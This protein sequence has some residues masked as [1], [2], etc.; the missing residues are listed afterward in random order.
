[1]KEALDVRR[2]VT[3]AG[4]DVFG[5]WI[6]G[7]RDARTQ[8]KIVAC[9]DRLALGNFGGCKS[10]GAG[11]YEL[12]INWGPGY[13]VYYALVGRTHVLLLCAGDK[14]SQSSDIQRARDYF[15]D[16]RERTK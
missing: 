6:S 13:R 11:L 15:K 7:L 12:R 10:L 9:V 4:R 1:M 8:A 5:E 16:Y 14:R 3:T 2:Y